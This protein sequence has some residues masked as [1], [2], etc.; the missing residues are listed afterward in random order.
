[1]FLSEQIVLQCFFSANYAFGA[2]FLQCH[3]VEKFI[4]NSVVEKFILVCSMYTALSS[5]NFGRDRF[6]DRLF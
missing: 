2:Q 4:G 6:W 3:L 1:M 5:E